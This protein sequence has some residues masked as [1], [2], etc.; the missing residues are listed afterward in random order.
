MQGRHWASVGYIL[1]FEF[2]AHL[3]DFGQLGRDDQV[4]RNRLRASE[5]DAV[6]IQLQFFELA[7]LALL[8][9]IANDDGAL[10]FQ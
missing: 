2:W 10:V 1:Q 4:G 9:R 5:R 3:L 8:Q 7:D 6:V